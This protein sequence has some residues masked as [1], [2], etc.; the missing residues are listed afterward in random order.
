MVATGHELGNHSYTHPH[1]DRISH[2]QLLVE[3]NLTARL[4]ESL[5]GARTLPSASSGTAPVVATFR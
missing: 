4:F 1:F 3:L 2:A 5:V